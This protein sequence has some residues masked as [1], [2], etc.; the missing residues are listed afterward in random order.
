MEAAHGP[1]R[2]RLQ[3][4]DAL[5][6][7]D[8]QRDFMP[9]GALAVPHGDAVIAPVNVCIERF[10]AHG[11]PVYASRDWHPQ[12]HCS[13]A[14][15]GGPWPRHGVAGTAGAAFAD[16]LHLPPQVR[17]V[18]KGHERG[19]EAYSAFAGT[20]LHQQLRTGHVLRLFVV[21]VATEYCVAS[22]VLDALALGYRVVVVTDAIAA[23]DVQPGDGERALARMR[24]SGAQLAR[25]SELH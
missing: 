23:V 8:V 5:L 25:S 24:E 15:A 6:I 16:G 1:A 22:S 20:G 18:S 14:Q 13:F 17:V 19:S 11:L 2:W 9:G 4:D 7:V 21:G 10:V 3:H 12:G